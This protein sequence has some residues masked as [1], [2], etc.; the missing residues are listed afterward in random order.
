MFIKEKP[1][2]TEN[3]ES[4]KNLLNFLDKSS[5]GN[6]VEPNEEAENNDS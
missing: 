4:L 2:V 6:R 3:K 1:E 5:K